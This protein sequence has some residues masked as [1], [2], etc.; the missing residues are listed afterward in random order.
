MKFSKK[1]LPNG[2]RII[3][4]PMKDNPTVTVMVLVE[5]GSKYETKKNNGISH[6][7]EHL[8]FKG[9][10]LR[11]TAQSISHELDS[12]GAHYNAFTSHEFTGYF[13]KSS[14]NH[15][16]KILDIV[17][18]IYLHSTLPEKEIEKE[19]GVIVEEIN[20]YEDIPQRQV[21]DEFMALLFGDQ[22]AGF[23]VTGSKEN[24]LGFRRSDFAD[25]RT[26]HYVAQA[27]TVI[28]AGNF[29]EEKVIAAVSEKFSKIST[30]PKA[31]KPAVVERQTKPAV[32]VKEK[33]TD[34]VHLV[35]GL[36][37]IRAADPRNAAFRVLATMLGGGMSSRLFVRLR[38]EMGVCYY[39]SASHD[40]MTDHG[41][42]E[43]S[44]GVD[45]KRVAEVVETLIAEL[46]KTKEDE[47]SAAELTK[48]KE[49]IVGT[50]SLSLESSDALADFYGFQ[51][52]M[53]RKLEQ[54]DQIA[55]EIR[56]V[57]AADLRRVANDF[58]VT[59]HLNL[60]LIGKDIA[61]PPL[62]RLLVL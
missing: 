52:L 22:P 44:A 41:L 26:A 39:V 16:A 18:D 12:L 32:A 47:V 27:T 7:L 30:G 29:E 55:R 33:V 3:T 43:I 9:T 23:P 15:Q 28:V 60:A 42:F 2:L 20:M 24:V 6:F 34:Q 35:L 5:A 19:K 57:T 38:E 40:P 21:Q 8:C 53:R 54:P 31:G 4:V 14:A 49:Y 17:S 62:R 56:A 50:M 48:V 25:Y 13:A 59:E 51:E 10:T 45:K 37:S 46:K 11:P 61:A 36:P 58:F 1:T